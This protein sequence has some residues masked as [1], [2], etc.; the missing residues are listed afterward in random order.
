MDRLI[1]FSP[2]LSDQQSSFPIDRPPD[3]QHQPDDNIDI[4]G[5]SV[6]AMT[7]HGEG[8]GA[9]DI[10]VSTGFGFSPHPDSIMRVQDSSLPDTLTPKLYTGGATGSGNNL[11]WKQPHYVPSS[12]DRC[13]RCSGCGTKTCMSK[14]SK[15]EEVLEAN[16][17]RCCVNCADKKVC[18]QRTGAYG[19]HCDLWASHMV[20]NHQRAMFEYNQSARSHYAKENV[21]ALGPDGLYF[22]K[23]GVATAP[24]HETPPPGYRTLPR[25]PPGGKLEV[26]EETEEEVNAGSGADTMS[27]EGVGRAASPPPIHKQDRLIGSP[28]N[29]PSANLA[30]RVMSSPGFKSFET[31]QNKQL[32]ELRQDINMNLGQITDLKL[33]LKTGFSTVGDSINKGLSSVETMIKR[34]TSTISNVESN[35][36]Q[37]RDELTEIKQDIMMNRTDLEQMRRDVR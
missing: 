2:E 33:E 34:L 28:L 16:N 6:M 35:Q 13:G 21:L 36:T 32:A 26:V 17:A 23:H 3:H 9:D 20:D 18:V 4:F 27:G 22:L 30:Q 19:G 1:S 14:G 24:E 29:S 12:K 7:A 31:N 10:G 15:L 37:T 25:T 8:D 5:T 11:Y